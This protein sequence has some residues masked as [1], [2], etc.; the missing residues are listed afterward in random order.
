MV[1]K[2]PL[3]TGFYQFNIS[4]RS[5]NAAFRLFLESMQYIHRIAETNRI[6][7][8]VGVAMVIFNNFQNAS[9]AKTFEW[10]CSR[11]L[12]S[13]LCHI[14]CKA[15]ELFDRIGKVSKIIFG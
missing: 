11:V 4:L 12:T 13:G 10:F 6:N 1:L 5:G 14:E 9:T 3:E 15:H 7:S 8:P 2:C